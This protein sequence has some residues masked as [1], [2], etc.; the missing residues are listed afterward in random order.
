MGV[1][2]RNVKLLAFVTGASFGG[3][4]G[5]MFAGFQGFVSPESST[6]WGSLVVLQCVVLGGIGH[7]AG[8]IL[9]ALLLAVLPEVLRSTMKL[10]QYAIFGLQLVDTEVT[11]QLVYRLAM[12][13]I[14]LRRPEGLW[15]AA[16]HE[17][18]IA[19]IARRDNKK[20]VR[21]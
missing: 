1:N 5:T 10:L 20:P 13:V 11:R 2:T 4:S 9:G 7:I 3:L 19:K 6:L 21:A 15:P 8:A 14:M 16:K 17:D 18:R 12:V